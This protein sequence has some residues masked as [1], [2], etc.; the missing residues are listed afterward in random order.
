VQVG[1][2]VELEQRV[3]DVLDELVGGGIELLGPVQ[4]DVA[5]RSL[6][7]VEHR[8]KRGRRILACGHRALLSRPGRFGDPRPAQRDSTA[9]ATP[10]ANGSRSVDV[11]RRRARAELR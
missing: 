11:H 6:L 3:V 4:R 5:D 2:G 8:L 9:A 7:V 1:I 10:R